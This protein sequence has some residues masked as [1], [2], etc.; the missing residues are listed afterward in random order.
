MAAKILSVLALRV[1]LVEATKKRRARA[2]GTKATLNRVDNICGSGPH[3]EIRLATANKTK[4]RVKTVIDNLNDLERMFLTDHN[5]NSRAET[6]INKRRL[7]RSKTL[8][9]K[10]LNSSGKRKTK[11]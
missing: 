4:G 5:R 8:A 6:K 2:T 11:P 3:E 1:L 10:G 7:G 9:T